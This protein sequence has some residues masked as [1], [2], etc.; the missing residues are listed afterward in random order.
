[1]KS[2]FISISSYEMIYFVLN[3]GL[4]FFFADQWKS[5]RWPQAMGTVLRNQNK[6]EW[7]SSTSVP[8]AHLWASDPLSWVSSPL[9]DA[10]FK[11]SLLAKI[12]VKGHSSRI[13][14]LGRVGP[15]LLNSWK[16]TPWW[17][18]FPCVKKVEFHRLQK[19][20]R[21]S[22]RCSRLILKIHRKAGEERGVNIVMF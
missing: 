10:E 13:R 7:R 2:V 20:A 11:V 3:C 15:C 22:A 12:R 21:S 1:M 5:N 18:I 4:H 14:S 19:Q 9:T 6:K 16:I 8:G 17:D